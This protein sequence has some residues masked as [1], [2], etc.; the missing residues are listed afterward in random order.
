MILV[1]PGVEGCHDATG[2]TVGG[3]IGY[4]WQASS[5][6]FGLEAQGNWADFKGSNPNLFFP[7]VLDKSKIDAF[8]LFTAQIGY[9]WNNVLVY[10]KGGAA[11]TRDKYATYDIPTGLAHDYASENRWGGVVGVASIPVLRRTGRSHLNTTTCSWARVMLN[12]YTSGNFGP[13]GAFSTAGPYRSGC[14]SG[15]RPPE[16]QVRHGRSGCCPLL[17]RSAQISRNSKPRHRPGFFVGL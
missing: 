14:R 7:G 15:Y 2:G 9:A 17:I 11:V 12:F 8:G 4:R 13:A 10:V 1:P 6:V 16:L 3:Q 5:W